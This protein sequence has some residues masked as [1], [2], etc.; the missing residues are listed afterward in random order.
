MSQDERPT[1]TRETTE[2]TIRAILREAQTIAVVGLSPDPSRPSNGVARYLQAQ[3]YRIIPVNPLETE[4]LGE[5]SYPTL[6]DIPVRVDVVD[7]FRRSEFVPAI[8]EEAVKIGATA[9]WLQF[10]VISPEGE[11]TAKRGGLRVVVDRC[12]K[13]EHA[14]YGKG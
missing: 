13:V 2:Q 3:G 8:A 6:S 5:T 14:R 4:L 7:V 12:I 1:E 9:L 11:A 10:D